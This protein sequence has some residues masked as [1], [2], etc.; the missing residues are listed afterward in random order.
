MSGGVDV[1]DVMCLGDVFFV[2]VVQE[3]RFIFQNMLSNFFQM[4]FLLQGASI[5]I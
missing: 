4:F 2:A 3:S 1:G 5:E